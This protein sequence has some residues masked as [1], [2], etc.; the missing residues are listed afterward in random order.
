MKKLARSPKLHFDGTFETAPHIFAQ[1]LSILSEYRDE[2][3]PLIF[4]LLPN[5]S[6]ET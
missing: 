4:A 2:T 6:E 3:L 1:I 5:K